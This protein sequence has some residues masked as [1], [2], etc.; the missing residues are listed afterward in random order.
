MEPKYYIYNADVICN[1]CGAAYRGYPL[2]G[3]DE[4]AGQE[5]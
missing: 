1:D 3:Y 2:P 5:E 4:E